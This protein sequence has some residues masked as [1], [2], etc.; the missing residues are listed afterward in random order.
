[1]KRKILKNIKSKQSIMATM[2][3]A[4]MIL[5]GLSGSNIVFK[6]TSVKAEEY[7]I[8]YDV[9]AESSSFL[10]SKAIIIDNA[11]IAT[12]LNGFPLL[13]NDTTGNLAGIKA[14]G[15]D[16]AFFAQGNVTQLPHE[17][18]A[19]DATSG[20]LTAWVNVSS[21]SPSA[22]T[23]IYMFYNDTDG[24]YPRGYNPTNVWDQHYIAVYHM[25]YTTTQ[26]NDSTSNDNHAT[27]LGAITNA[28][29]KIGVAKDFDGSTNYI[30]LTQSCWMEGSDFGTFE[31]WFEPDITNA[32]MGMF[33]QRDDNNS[34]YAYSR[35][36]ATAGL[37]FEGKRGNANTWYV[38]SAGSYDTTNQY[39]AYPMKT[40]DVHLIRNTNPELNDDNCGMPE[41]NSS[42]FECIRVGVTENLVDNRFFDGQ[43]DEVRLSNISRNSSWLNATYHSQNQTTGFLTLGEQQQNEDTASTYEI[44]GLE[45][46][47]KNITWT[48][49][50]GTTVWS[51]ATQP[52]GTL[53]LNMS[54]NTSDNITEIRV[55]CDDL[56][57]SILASNIT[58]YVS[59]DNSS[60]DTLGAF[61]DGGSNISINTSTWPVGSGTNPFTYGGGTGLTNTNTSIYM[62]FSLTLGT[63]AG[64]FNQNDW[65]IYLGYYG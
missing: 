49:T 34:D 21:I 53:E 25:N 8:Q 65:K 44:K 24:G 19:F 39:F 15:S 17:I 26:C 52:G 16:I 7:W 60:Y 63:T 35:F 4:L 2:I 3:V 54:I 62:R 12:Y 29:G 59:S 56:D 9:Q 64:T 36:S 48:G 32:W 58:L 61:T 18:E 33:E 22:K 20:N 40:D 45:G 47:W 1:M 37:R 6:D 43:V 31:A 30:N 41:E 23:Y 51:N 13:V 5:V 27:H 50:T 57:A 55:Y 38:D 28:N 14:N 46:S 42:H 11:Y 10:Y